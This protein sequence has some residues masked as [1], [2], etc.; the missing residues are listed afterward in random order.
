MEEKAG[1]VASEFTTLGRSPNINVEAGYYEDQEGAQTALRVLQNGLT[2]SA[3][4]EEIRKPS[5]GE[6]CFA[7]HIMGK[8][9]YVDKTRFIKQLFDKDCKVLLFTRPSHFGKTHFMTMLNSF[10]GELE[11]RDLFSGLQIKEKYL[12]FFEEHQ[13][14]YLV[15]FIDLATVN[16]FN[17]HDD[18]LR[19][20]AKSIQELYRRV[21]SRLLEK[22]SGCELSEDITKILGLK[23]E[24]D[25]KI[26]EY[27]LKYSLDALLRWVIKYIQPMSVKILIDAYDSAIQSVFLSSNLGLSQAVLDVLRDFL[28]IPLKSIDF[29]YNDAVITGVSRLE[30]QAMPSQFLNIVTHFSMLDDGFSDCFGFTSIEV[31]SVLNDC[32]LLGC[33]DQVVEWYGNYYCGSTHLVNPWALL[34]Y[35]SARFSNSDLITVKYFNYWENDYN[36]KMA[37]DVLKKLS[38]AEIDKGLCFMEKLFAK[39]LVD[40]LLD[41]SIALSLSDKTINEPSWLASFFVMIGFMSYIPLVRENPQESCEKF[42]ITIP[43]RELHGFF[44]KN[45]PRNQQCQPR[46]R[47]SSIDHSKRQSGDFCDVDRLDGE[48]VM[49]N[50]DKSDGES[51][52]LE[53]DSS[54]QG[55]S[56]DL[57][58][59]SGQARIPS[60]VN[61]SAS[62]QYGSDQIDGERLILNQGTKSTDPLES[63][64]PE[65]QE[66]LP[67]KSSGGGCLIL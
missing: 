29:L 38:S 23:I 27:M 42:H 65:D 48:F 18:F 32:K 47:L 21:S 35:L 36:G 19:K 10:Y 2:S 64:V 45:L 11:H 14:Q 53:L 12:D 60:L 13:G 7:S 50:V 33:Y 24:D 34:N 8:R 67:A 58:S 22:F 49:H 31:K 3:E 56:V 55:R 41:S 61:N 20:F 30:Q 17:T 26:D 44:A 66:K 62:F 40:V 37:I 25:S 28:S 1:Q 43:N 6:P 51:T 54:G 52:N 59:K 4:L 15:I 46:K 16:S 5:V 9:Y 57:N 63:K 39:E